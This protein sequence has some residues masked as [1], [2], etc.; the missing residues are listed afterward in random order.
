MKFSCDKSIL[1]EAVSKVG[2]IVPSKANIHAIEGIYLQLFDD[3]M[4]KL[5]GYDFTVGIETYI[6]TEY[7]EAGSI[8]VNAK[9]FSDIL[10]N[11][12]SGT[13]TVSSTDNA[14]VKISCENLDFTIVCMEGD[15][16]PNVPLVEKDDQLIIKQGDLCELIRKTS[17]TIIQSDI[18]PILKGILVKVDSEGLVFVS[19]DTFRL[20][21]CRHDGEFTNKKGNDINSVVPGRAFV[22]LLKLFDSSKNEE[23][24]TICFSENHCSFETADFRMITSLIKGEFVNY[25]KITPV[26]YKN[27]VK[28]R[29]EDLASAVSRASLLLSNEKLATPIRFGFEFDHVIISL[30]KDNG[31]RY[32]DEIGIELNG[33]NFEIGFNNKH[34]LGI[35]SCISEEYIYMKT[36]SPLSPACITSVEGDNYY[37]LISPMRI[38]AK[39][40]SAQ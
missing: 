14:T 37:Y 16:F 30:F 32:T 34:L 8:I 40:G 23:D 27:T 35:L 1:S 11:I 15:L 31:H 39:P 25:K 6:Q 10:N 20:S 19:S 36:N 33:E 12:P 24:V 18:T 26:Q 4:L 28:I 13:V 9:L 21:V 5:T 38:T 2:K 3:G 7:S 17:A 29:V 22:E